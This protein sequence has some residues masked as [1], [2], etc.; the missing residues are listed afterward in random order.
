[1]ANRPLPQRLCSRAA[2]LSAS[3]LCAT[4]VFVAAPPAG[5]QAAAP[6]TTT[7][8]VSPTSTTY[9]DAVTYMITVTSSA[10]TPQGDAFFE[11]GGKPI[12]GVTVLTNGSG[13]CSAST[14]PGGDD[15]VTAVFPGNAAFAASS[16]TTNLTVNVTEPAPPAGATQSNSGASTD[17]SGSI[18]V[19]S[20]E[21]FVQAN[22]PGAVTVATYG[23]NPTPAP[24]KGTTEVWGDVTLGTGSSFSSVLVA[25]CDAGAGASLEYFNGTSWNE[26][27]EQSTSADCLFGLVDSSTSPTLADLTGTPVAVSWLPPPGYAHGYWLVARDGGIFSF[28]RAFHGSTGSIRLNQPIVGMAATHDGGGYWLA[29]AD[30]GVFTFG[31]AHFLGSIPSEERAPTTKVVAIVADPLSGGYYLIRNDGTVYGFHA[32]S[33]GDLPL[34]GFHVSDIVGG[35]MTSDGKGMYLVGANGTVYRLLGDATFQGDV[36][37]LHL[38]APIIG[39]AIDPA[40]EGYWL[41]A[42]DGGVFSFDAHFYGSTGNLKLNQPV[43][44]MTATA[45]GGGYWF[46]AAD[47]GVF[48][49]GDAH[50]YGSTGNIHLN[51]PVVGMAGG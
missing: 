40:T 26:F 5:A 18:K 14:A 49:F 46:V 31:D 27:S 48:S 38:N 6:T 41:L 13:T 1:M 47:G 24:L 9:G 16:G 32:P 42:K 30:G 43:V 50:Y 15:V 51:Q 17:D 36:S 19:N 39:M 21:L 8:S 22:G 7:A 10:A 3:A 25:E 28:G 34:F 45:D 23:A 20:G 11:I 44:G 2:L 35:A 12:C 4:L 33:Y 37:S 29:A